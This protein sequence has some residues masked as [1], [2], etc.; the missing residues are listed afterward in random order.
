MREVTSLVAGSAPG[1][2]SYRASVILSGDV[3]AT[4]NAPVKIDR[5]TC[6]LLAVEDSDSPDICINRCYGYIGSQI[7]LDG[8]GK[9]CS[10]SRLIWCWFIAFQHGQLELLCTTTGSISPSEV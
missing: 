7:E 6:L 9:A 2:L 10:D 5:P 8:P 1:L 3:A 4:G